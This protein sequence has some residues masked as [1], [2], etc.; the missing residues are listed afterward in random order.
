METPLETTFFTDEQAVTQ[1][2]VIFMGKIVE[3]LGVEFNQAKY[4]DFLSSKSKSPRVARQYRKVSSE[5]HSRVSLETSP[6]MAC[7]NRAISGRVARMARINVSHE[8]REANVIE[9]QFA[10]P[11]LS[12][13]LSSRLPGVLNNRQV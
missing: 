9:G 7:A 11:L 10:T 6:N 13:F 8:T 12:T 1:G 5:I 4:E 2:D 3:S